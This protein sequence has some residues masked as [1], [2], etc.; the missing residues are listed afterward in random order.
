MARALDIV[1]ERWTLLILRE[2]MLG[3]KRFTD[4]LDAL[5]GLARNLLT[6]RL[7]R[8]EAEGLVERTTL[9]PPAA[10]RVYALTESGRALGPSMA[11]LGRWGIEQLPPAPAKAY[12]RPEWAVFPLSYMA[13]S[14]AARGVH[15]VYELV[16]DEQRFHLRVDDGEVHPHAGGAQDPDLVIAMSAGTLRDLFFGGLDPADAVARSLVRFEGPPET[17]GRAMAIL[18]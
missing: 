6:E 3:P 8:L 13:N 12:F 17:I 10:S 5:P 11:A 4:L 1:G 15:E 7:R 18:A 2:L 14:D 16:I 9:P